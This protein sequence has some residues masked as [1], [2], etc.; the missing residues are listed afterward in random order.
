MTSSAQC[1]A[2]WSNQSVGGAGVVVVLEQL[3]RTG[4]LPQA[5]VDNSP[6]FT[7]KSLHN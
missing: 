7:G 4:G 6:E 1:P 5:N 2:L 3:A